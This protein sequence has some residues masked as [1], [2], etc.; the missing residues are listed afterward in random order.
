LNQQAASA[1]RNL[2]NSSPAVG[3]GTPS[4]LDRAATPESWAALADHSASRRGY[5]TEGPIGAAD[6]AR[7][8]PR[9]SLIVDRDHADALGDR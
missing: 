5:P 1:P 7:S 3:K 4:L 6:G 2:I 9:M 8:P